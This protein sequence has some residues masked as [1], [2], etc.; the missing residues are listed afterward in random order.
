LIFSDRVREFIM[1][2]AN[3]QKPTYDLPADRAAM[4]AYATPAPVAGSPLAAGVWITVAGLALIGLGGCF[5]IGVMISA[6]IPTGFHFVIVLYAL[7]FTCFAA[8]AYLLFLGI[9]KLLSVGR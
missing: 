4:L 9:S 8:A 3:Q 1:D 5:M 7:A 6:N 2:D